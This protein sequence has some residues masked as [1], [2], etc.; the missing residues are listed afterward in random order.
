MPIMSTH[1]IYF[2]AA[3]LFLGSLGNEHFQSD[4]KVILKEL[5]PDHAHLS[6]KGYG[7]RDHGE[8]NCEGAESCNL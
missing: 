3:S 5:M 1:M 8:G 4:Q 6:H 2:D 7:I